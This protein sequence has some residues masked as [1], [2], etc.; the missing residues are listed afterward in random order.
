[1]I[2]SVVE[3]FVNDPQIG[4]AKRE[5]F[6]ET[7]TSKVKVYTLASI[8]T[9]HVLYIKNECEIQ[10]FHIFNTKGMRINDNRANFAAKV[11]E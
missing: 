7:K 5:D 1:L 2:D 8:N 4:L 3:D 10:L 11:N 6:E 9:L